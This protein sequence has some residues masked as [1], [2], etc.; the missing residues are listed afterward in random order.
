MTPL[1]M[2]LI[3][4]PCM[5]RDELQAERTILVRNMSCIFKTAQLELQRKDEQLRELRRPKPGV[6]PQHPL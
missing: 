1:G 2:Q 6:P 5:Q 3:V 4:S